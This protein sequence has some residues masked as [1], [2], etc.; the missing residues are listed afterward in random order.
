VWLFAGSV[1]GRR[2][3][4]APVLGVLGFFYVAN[5]LYW[6]CNYIF[7]MLQLIVIVIPSFVVHV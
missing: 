2:G 4:G 7:V 5:V 3:G 6:C 1:V